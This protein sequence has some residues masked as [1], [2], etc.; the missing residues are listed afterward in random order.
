[1]ILLADYVA[2]HDPLDGRPSWRWVLVDIGTGK[3]VGVGY[4]ATRLG[5]KADA[6]VVANEYA[7]RRRAA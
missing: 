7:Q 6:V 3:P 5:A 4:A 2:M 1:V